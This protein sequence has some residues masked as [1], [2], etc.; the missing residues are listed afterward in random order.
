MVLMRLTSLLMTGMR[1]GVLRAVALL[2]AM[3]GVVRRHCVAPLMIA[4]AA[5]IARILVGET[6]G[7][8][9]GEIGGIAEMAIVSIACRQGVMIVL[10]GFVIQH[11]K[12]ILPES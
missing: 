7:E 12:A 2:R 5:M 4:M 9:V 6:R 3:G 11:G 8:G 1:S 10:V